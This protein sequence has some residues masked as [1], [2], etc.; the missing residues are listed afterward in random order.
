VA[1]W[2]L[3][4]FPAIPYWEEER[5]SDVAQRVVAGR[6][7]LGR[8]NGCSDAV[9]GVMHKCWAMSAKERPAFSSLKMLLQDALGEA[10]ARA[11]REPCVV[12]LERAPVMALRP[13]GH[14]CVC[15]ECLALLTAAAPVEGTPACPLCRVPVEGSVRVFGN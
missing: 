15:A 9:W 4:S 7:L 12:C 13:C 10:T 8:P 14:K 6:N 5:D 1:L 11:A 3:E 2:E